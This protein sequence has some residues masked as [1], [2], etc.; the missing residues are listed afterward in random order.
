MADGE[1]ALVLFMQLESF[2]ATADF[3]EANMEASTIPV[4][5]DT[6]ELDLWGMYSSLWPQFS[7]ETDSMF[8]RLVLVDGAGCVAALLG[9]VDDQAFQ[10]Q[11]AAQLKQAWVE[12]LHSDCS[13]RVAESAEEADL[14][15]RVE[16][17]PELVEQ[18]DMTAEEEAGELHDV[19]GDPAI[20]TLEV[21]DGE[22]PLPD[23]QDTEVFDAAG[24]QTFPDVSGETDVEPF[25]LM[26]I[27]QVGAGVPIQ[28]GQ[29][30]PHFLCKD[31]NPKS[32]GY[33]GPVSDIALKGVAWIAYSGSCT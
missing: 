28:P 16:L 32:Q 4:L 8:Y 31:L 7:S 25:Q 12:A 23:A 27:C 17:V 29:Q 11:G 5:Q 22:Q 18:E 3:I 30:V 33:G 21:A 14:V 19:S 13:D 24:D 2:D 1:N 9:P 20:E 6:K 15:N 10:G 26:D